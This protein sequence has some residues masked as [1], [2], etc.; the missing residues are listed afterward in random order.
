MRL[1]GSVITGL[2]FILALHSGARCQTGIDSLRRILD[3]KTI[4]DTTV[5]TTAVRLC[6]MVVNTDK[7]FLLP[8][9]AKKGL[10]SDPMIRDKASVFALREYLGNYYWQVGRLSEAAEQFNQMR[11]IGERFVDRRIMA[12]SYNGLGTVYYLMGDN[13]QALKYYRDGLALSEKD[14]LLKVR[15]YNNIANTFMEMGKMDSVLFY[16][17][18][19]LIYH[20][21]HQNFRHLSIVYG[22][23]ALAYRKLHNSMEVRKNIDLALEAAVKTGDP[24]QIASV[25]QSMGEMALKQ[26]P[27]LASGCYNL[28]LNLARK[29]KSYDQIKTSLDSLAKIADA[30]G[31]FREEATYLKE[32]RRLTD[33][34][35]L[36]QKKSIIQ[37]MEAEHKA[38]VINATEIK[39]AQQEEDRLIREKIRQKNILIIICILLAAA[40]AIF[41]MR[42]QNYRLK[43]KINR[44]KESFFSMIAHD[45]RN[46]FSGILGLSGILN[47]EAEKSPDPVHRKRVASLHQSLNQV[48][49]LLENL[50]QWS[51]SETGKIAFNPMVQLLSPVIH[52]VMCL[53]TAAARKK[54]IHLENQVQSDLTARFDSNMLQ[55]VIR[56]LLSNSIKFSP[57]NT[58]IFFS[59]EVRG[60]EVVVKV[61]DEGIG[62]TREQ[63]DQIFKSDKSISTHGTQ[64]ESGTGLGLILCKEFITRHGGKIW[65][66]S[67]PGSGTTMFF[68]LPDRAR[69]FSF[70]SGSM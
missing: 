35:D 23:L 17:S 39:K 9:Y 21:A 6:R 29:S 56:N 60:N 13:V 70:R 64:N 65:A 31:K 50:L 15:F 18:N 57:E 16:Y 7:Q 2:I 48:Y 1:L 67:Q 46:P 33:S 43:I 28:A 3:T 47:E 61:K 45:I 37:L 22:N 69:K 42:I 58:G 49:D 8:D 5:I 40:L 25:Y 52:E 38:G 59:A 27:G 55:T 54:G 12:N 26:H 41:L 4:P 36:E 14:S 66:E 51:Q 30:E 32:S 20:K 34:L 11:I 63:I 19:S 10:E 62:M 68:T 24:Y 44:T 53:H